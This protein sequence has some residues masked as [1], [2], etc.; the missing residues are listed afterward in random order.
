MCWHIQR[1]SNTEKRV[2]ANQYKIPIKWFAFKKK[3]DKQLKYQFLEKAIRDRERK[4]SRNHNKT[5]TFGNWIDNYRFLVLH[6][7][8]WWIS[9]IFGAL[10]GAVVVAIVTVVVIFYII[11]EMFW[12]VIDGLQYMLV[13]IRL[14]LSWMMV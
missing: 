3:C 13:V 7:A 5:C 10:I 4:N 6:L 14:R 9:I 2:T 11:V 8:V 12:R 1:D